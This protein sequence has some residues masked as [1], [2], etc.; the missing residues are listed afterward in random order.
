MAT[1]FDFN[2]IQTRLKEAEKGLSLSLA[3]VAKNDFLNNFREQGFN[4]QKWREVQ[5]RIAGTRAY[6]GNKDL[7]KRTRAILQGKGSGRL[8]KDVANSV[9]NGI[10]H[11]ELSYTL[12][13]KNEYSNYH[14]EGTA[15]IPQRQFVGM[16]EKLNKKLL[17][18]INEKFSKIW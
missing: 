13:V 3:N 15:K 12:I 17:N 8:R 7:G 11:S 2:R 18:K 9:S 6:A 14:N 4:G 10:K 16:T 1:Q 5:R